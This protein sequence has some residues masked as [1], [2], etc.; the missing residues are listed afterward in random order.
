M[1][2]LTVSM[3]AYDS[4][5]YI[6]S[7]IDSVLKQD[8]IDFELIVVD[9]G[10]QDNTAE[11]VLS[12]KDP[13]VR[14]ITNKKN[15]GTAYCH[16]LVFEQ[17]TSPFVAHVDSEDLVLPGAFQK[18][19]AKLKSDP[20]I[21]QVHCYFFDIDENSRT[22]RDAFHERRLSLLEKIRPH[23]DYK[24][25]LLVQGSVM[26]H[27]RT[28]RREVF[29]EVGKFNEKLRYGEDYDMA[30]RIVDKFDIKLVPEFLY[31][32]RVHK[33]DI[34]KSSYV[35]N[36]HRFVQR[37]SISRNLLKSRKIR[38]VKE[39]KYNINRLTVV[40]LYYALGLPKMTDFI[41]RKILIFIEDCKVV[42]R[43]ELTSI[44]RRVYY[45]LFDLFSWWPIDLFEFK[46]EKT[47]TEEKRI[48][49]YLWH[50]PI[51]SE[52]FIQREVRALREWGISL[53]IVAD[54]PDNLEYLDEDTKSLVKNTRYLYPKNEKIK[55]SLRY[56]KYFFFKN[57]LSFLCLFLYVVFHRY[58]HSK[59][60][61]HDTIIFLRSVYLAGALKD[62]N[63]NHIHSPWADVNAF[64]S[65]IASKL[66][67]IPYTVQARA[68]DVHRKTYLYATAEKFMNAEFVVTNTRYNESHLKSFLDREAWGKIHTIYN[69]INLDQFEPRPDSR[70]TSNQIVILSVARLIEQKGLVYLLKSCRILKDRGY[71]FTCNVIGGLEKPLYINYY[72]ML[73]KL[74]R[75]LGLE[76]R[77]FFLGDQ[78]FHKVL[79][80]YRNADI[81][82]LPCV[83]AEDGSRD[84]TPNSLIE[85]MAMKLPVIS[86]NVTGI[87]EIVENDVSGILIPSHNEIALAEAI[88]KLIEN[89]HLRKELGENARKKIEERFDINKNVVQYVGLFE[90]RLKNKRHTD[91]RPTPGL[92]LGCG[93]RR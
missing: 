64:V 85:A 70:N 17:S 50:Y 54:A 16:N 28:Y 41:R 79:E 62:M 9:D 23:M 35:N 78:P 1:P 27:L 72:V 58:H 69:G 52:T 6:K 93:A 18:M 38:F 5:Q 36:L 67:K 43:L 88:I 44:F 74:H 57:P 24:R 25:E 49:Y 73:M 39:N 75:Q 80:E 65:L 3:P 59:N 89:Y 32:N 48:A 56:L 82:V 7:A 86:T 84:V 12:F 37:L 2:E 51:L 83:I 87:P 14:L 40:A 4:A 19:V 21:G 8:C 92:L 42:T 11:I 20:N 76:E 34:K 46:R 55:I 66:L 61:K 30:L 31:C 13:R 68:H 60:F 26:N 81:F 15:M 53:D 33:N 10:S 90:E 63:I 91:S 47:L 22:T 77:V 71:S 29:N 45:L